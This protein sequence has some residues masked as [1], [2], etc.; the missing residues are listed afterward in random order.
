MILRHAMTSGLGAGVP[1]REL[2]RQMQKLDKLMGR[3]WHEVETGGANPQ[4]RAAEGVAIDVWTKMAAKYRP[5]S[6]AQKEKLR[7]R[8]IEQHAKR[9]GFIVPEDKRAIYRR[10]QRTG[11]PLTRIKSRL[12]IN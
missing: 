10:L 5:T 8:A 3:E 6:E 1:P 11:M 2:M 9:R 4:H 12:G 7:H